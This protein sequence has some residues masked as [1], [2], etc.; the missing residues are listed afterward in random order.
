MRTLTFQ[1]FAAIYSETLEEVISFWNPAMQQEL[2]THCV[3]WTPENF[4]FENYLRCSLKRYHLAY[5]AIAAR[6][7]RR[8]ARGLVGAPSAKSEGG[9]PVC[10]GRPPA[11]R[12]SSA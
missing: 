7:M 12:R 3:D 8:V 4:D 5:R 2:A 11:S 10:R 6:V 9:A 1:Q